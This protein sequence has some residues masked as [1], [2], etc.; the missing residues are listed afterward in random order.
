MARP[1]GHWIEWDGAVETR[2]ELSRRLNDLY[3]GSPCCCGEN[4][5]PELG[6]RALLCHIWH[7]LRCRVGLCVWKAK[8]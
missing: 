5:H 3:F 7:A 6:I 2:D 8:V 4:V 1:R